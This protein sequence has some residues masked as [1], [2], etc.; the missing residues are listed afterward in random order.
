MCATGHLVYKTYRRRRYSYVC[1][2]QP[3]FGVNTT[4]GGDDMVGSCATTSRIVLTVTP[5]SLLGH[6]FSEI[7]LHRGRQTSMRLSWMVHSTLRVSI[8]NTGQYSLPYG[9]LMP[10]EHLRRFDNLSNW[11]A[12][13]KRLASDWQAIGKRRSSDWQKVSDDAVNIFHIARPS[14]KRVARDCIGKWVMTQ[15][16]FFT[17]GDALEFFTSPDLCQWQADST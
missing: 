13:D 17:R 16:K 2:W 10:T 11:H 1:H 5:G 7:H 4:T 14:V 3:R 8:C 15:L 12:I 9:C 6:S